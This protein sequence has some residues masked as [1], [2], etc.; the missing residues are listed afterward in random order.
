MTENAAPSDSEA[1]EFT[2]NAGYTASRDQ[3]LELYDSVGWSLYT[4][5]PDGLER[6]LAN[7]GF[8]LEA[9]Q[10]SELVGLVRCLSDGD[11]I[12]YLQDILVRP[13]HHRRGI[14]K[15]L[16]SEAIEHY[17]DRIRQI[18]LITDDEPGQRA[19]YES[20]GF[21]EISELQPNPG[22]CFV[23]FRN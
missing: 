18:V 6:A 4:R 2:I 22:R 3:V 16:V 11:T 12:L 1:P 7:S 17:P 9:W 14:G 8:V 20:L 10:G 13:T 19:F 5:D 21:T 23:Q 15:K